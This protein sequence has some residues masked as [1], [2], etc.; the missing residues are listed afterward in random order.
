VLDRCG[1]LD[2]ASILSRETATDHDA[3]HTHNDRKED[4]G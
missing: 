2:L 3:C 4:D 1:I